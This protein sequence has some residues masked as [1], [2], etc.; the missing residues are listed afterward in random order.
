MYMKSI[1]WISVVTL[2]AGVFLASSANY[3]IALEFV[4]CLAAAS[5]IVQALRARKYEWAAAF[6]VIAL[7]FNPVVPIALPD[8]TLRWLAVPC[9]GV[10]MAS[11]LYVKAI[12]R[13]AIVSLAARPTR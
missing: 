13:P 1:S 6:L 3:R 7:L 2:A 11:L 5:I 9:M 12:P 4:V 10:F 8:L